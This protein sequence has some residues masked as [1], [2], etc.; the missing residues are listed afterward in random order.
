MLEGA[1]ATEE[2]VTKAEGYVAS[3]ISNANNIYN[4]VNN[5]SNE[6][7]SSNAYQNSYMHSI[8]TSE[9]SSIK[10]SLKLFAIGAGAGLFIGVAIWAVD[11]FILEVRNNKREEK[12]EK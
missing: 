12:E 1:P 10:D 6:L 9:A 7:L 8:V 3:A 4:V 5:C 2:Q 11:A